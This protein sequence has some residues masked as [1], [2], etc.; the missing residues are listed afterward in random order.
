MNIE[1]TARK[2]AKDNSQ[3]LQKYKGLQVAI[4]KDGVI[5]TDTNFGSLFVKVKQMGKLAECMFD[6]IPN[7]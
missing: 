7:I 4:T 1:D 2:W 3:E 6:V 5:A